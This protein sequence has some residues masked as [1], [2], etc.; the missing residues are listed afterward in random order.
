MPASGVVALVD[1]PEDDSSGLYSV[2]RRSVDRTDVP[3]VRDRREAMGTDVARTPL[4]NQQ[5]TPPT[6]TIR[7]HTPILT[8][9]PGI[10]RRAQ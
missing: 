8:S 10:Y 3:V 9:G 7:N 6:T 4:H 2:R 1:Q 5:G